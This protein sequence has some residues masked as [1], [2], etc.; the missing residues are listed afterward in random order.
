MELNLKS[1]T[2]DNYK[3]HIIWKLR[4]RLLNELQNREEIIMEIGKYF[5][6][7]ENEGTTYQ[8]LCN[9]TQSLCIGKLIR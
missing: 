6:M 2:K 5:E 4:N 3:I 9:I 7:N 1:V 8:I